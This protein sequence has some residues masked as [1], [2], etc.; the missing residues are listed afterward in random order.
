MEPGDAMLKANKK[1]LRSSLDRHRRFCVILACL[2]LSGISVSCHPTP[3]RDADPAMGGGSSRP[4]DVDPR[5]AKIIGRVALAKIGYLPIMRLAR[6]A[7]WV[8]R[9]KRASAR[10]SD[11]A[12]LS[13][14]AGAGG[15]IE[16]FSKYAVVAGVTSQA[17]TPLPGPG[18]AAAIGIIVI[19]LIDAGLL[20]GAILHAIED[21][22]TT[23]TVTTTS[24]P[25]VATTM[26]MATTTPTVYVPP[27]ATTRPRPD[28]DEECYERCK[29]LLPSPSGD[30]QASEYR[31][32]YRECK[33]TL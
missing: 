2:F 23:T 24:S 8:T 10:R 7:G 16:V 1:S 33:G 13:Q 32:C 15:F 19:G 17:D 28:K 31:K 21:A 25:P 20:A 6:E 14:T 5:R 3:E 12:L 11:P 29:H 9:K 22:A 26:P 18:D 27:I 30:L 4:M